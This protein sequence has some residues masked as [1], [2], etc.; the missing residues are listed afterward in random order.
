MEELVLYR[1]G[2]PQTVGWYDVLVDGG[3]DRLLHRFCRM[4]NRH[5]WQDINGNTVQGDVLWTGDASATP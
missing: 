5:K 1:G 2:F 3:E 4:E